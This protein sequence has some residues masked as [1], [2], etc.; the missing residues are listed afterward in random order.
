MTSAINVLVNISSVL[1]RCR[2]AEEQ[3]AGDEPG[4][5]RAGR[6]DQTLKYNSPEEDK[7]PRRSMSVGATLK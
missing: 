3:E 2:T 5:A 1:R 6:L 4:L 7:R